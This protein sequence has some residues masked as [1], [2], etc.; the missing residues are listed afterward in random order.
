M[1]SRW[2]RLVAAKFVLAAVLGVSAVASAQVAA[3]DTL[4]DV[5]LRDADI[6]TAIS[7]LTART[8]IMFI[9]EP[10]SQEYGKITLNL[11]RQKASDVIKYICQAAGAYY[12]RD[13]NGAYIISHNAPVPPPSTGEASNSNKVKVFRRIQLQKADPRDVYL[14]LLNINPYDFAARFREQKDFDKVLNPPQF[15]AYDP[16]VPSNL[17]TAVQPQ[18]VVHTYQAPRTSGESGNDIQLPGEPAQQVGGGGDGG[19][20]GGFGGGGGQGGGVGGGG[21]GG[22]FRGGFIPPGID[23]VSFDP[24]D[25]SLLVSG[26]EDA[27]EALENLIQEFDRAPKQVEIKVE[28]VTTASTIGSGLGYDVQF[29]RGTFLF[30]SAFAET[31]SPFFLAYSTGNLAFRLRTLLDETHGHSVQAPTLRTMN[32]QPASITATTQT[33]LFLTQIQTTPNGNITTVQPTTFSARTFLAV[34]PRI[35][36]DGTITMFLAPQIADFGQIRHGPN[37][38]DVPDLISQGISVVAR[39]KNGETIA[40]GGLNKKNDLSSRRRYPILSELPILG[41]FFR[42]RTTSRNDTELIIFVTPTVVEDDT[43][44]TPGVVTP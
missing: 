24:T 28:F 7:M 34:T 16:N 44:N 17:P 41:Q 21:Q 35:N 4:V 10:T 6:S 13:E 18:Q 40:L 31:T 20:F 39:V 19:G 25:N 8:G 37:G 36:N 23:I 12:H 11:T 43:S 27:I 33:T 26:T 9:F 22:A 5:S 15:P 38:T 42:Q 14:S 1:R 3:E 2:F 29:Q 32:N 30:N